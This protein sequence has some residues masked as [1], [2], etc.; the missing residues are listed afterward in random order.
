MKNRVFKIIMV[1]VIILTMTM[2]NFVFV[3]SSLISYAVDGIATNHQNVEFKAYFKNEEGEEVATLET[4]PNEEETF[5]YLRV[6]VKKEGYFNGEITLDES[7]FTLKETD[8]SYVSK[9]ENNTIYLNQINV[10]TTEEIKVKIEPNVEEYFTIGLLSMDSEISIKGIYRDSTQKDINIKSSRNVKLELTENNTS[11]DV[12]N[13]MQ[14]I[15]N[16]IVEIDGQEKRMIQFSYN[17]GL[18]ENNY[19]IKE[20]SSKIT[21]P[22]IDGKQ[23]EV[24]KNVYFNNMTYYNYKYDG[25]T[26]EFTL[27]N[28]PTTE[29]KVMWKEEG[30]ENIIITCFYDKEVEIENTVL[31]AQEKITLYDDKEI[32]TVNEV[33]IGAEELDSIIEIDTSNSEEMIYKGKIN[34]GIDR[35]YKS[36]TQVKINS[37]SIVK[38]IIISEDSSKY[39]VNGNEQEA[40]VTYSNTTIS[41]EQFDKLF[42]ENGQIT[43]YD[44]NSEVIKTITNETK[45]DQDGNII[46]DYNGKEVTKLSI[47]T[48]NPVEEGT[49]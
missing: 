20:I 15:T 47:Q 36:T 11:S 13:Q 24:D 4:K 31:N 34:A 30:S 21:I 35:Q 19:P 39:I 17:L 10:G 42:G 45:A 29:G 1:L 26:I 14:L 37:I 40:N 8:S 43:I 5:L 22:S 41:K 44:Q 46:I 12:L 9:I 28:E 49:L 48:S 32:E 38:D 3:G 2:T 7:N 25:N 23:A 27:T 33:T 16:K 18:I 6:N